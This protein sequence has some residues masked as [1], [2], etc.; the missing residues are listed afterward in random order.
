MRLQRF[1]PLF[2]GFLLIFYLPASG[3][4]QSVGDVESYEVEGDAVL[5]HCAQTKIRLDLLAA[6][7]VRVRLG[8]RGTFERDF[9]WAVIKEEW[10]SIDWHLA[11][12]DSLLMVTTPELSVKIGLHPCRIAFYT[13]AGAF[14][15]G[16]D[17]GKGMGWDGDQVRCWRVLPEDEHYYGFGEKTGPL[18][19]R[20]TCMVMWNS[21]IPG[22]RSYT[23][24]IYASIPFFLAL[25][26]GR[27]YGIYFDNVHRTSF[28]M[29]VESLSYYSFGA[30]G[31]ELD[32]YF[33]YGPHPK[34]VLERYTE[35]V[36]RMP[37]PPRWALGYQQCRWSYFPESRVRE[38][39]DSFRQGRIPCDVIYLDIDYMDGFR[40][41]TWDHS[42]FPDPEKMIDDLRE[43]GF[44]IVVIIDPGIKR[45]PGYWVYDDG[46][47]GDHFCRLPDGEMYVGQVW[48]GQCVF[49]DFTQEATRRWWG[50][51]YKG[52]I[53]VGIKGLWNDMNE[54]A[55]W[56]GPGGTFP[57][58]LLH[59]NEGR[60]VGHPACHNI[61][62]M[63]MARSTYEGVK[64][65]RPGERP[66]V[67]TRA[68]FAGLQRYTAMWTGDNVA[69]WEDLR[70]S[71]PML[72]NIGVSGQPF[73]GAD[74]G[75][76]IGTP[77]GELYA[78][79][80]QTGIFYGLCRTHTVTGSA[81]QEP[82]SFGEEF[83]G[84]NRR[85]IEL[86]YRLLPYLYN[87]FYQ[88]TQLG[89]PVVR[90]TWL[91][92]PM[93]ERTYGQDTEFMFG[94]DLLIG[95][96]LWPG[97]TERR[98]YLPRG[99]W[100]DFRTGQ[101]YTGGTDVSVSVDLST[102]PIFARAGAIIPMQPVVQYSD[103][104]PVD[105]LA[106]SIFPT[107]TSTYTLYEDDG[108]SFDYEDGE[109]ALV[110][111]TCEE[112]NGSVVVHI[113]ERR[114]E[115]T[116]PERWYMLQIH[117]LGDEPR[118]VEESGVKLVRSTTLDG[119]K[120]SESGWFYQKETSTA[121]V[122]IRDTGRAETIELK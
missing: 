83:E 23:D 10:P 60:P 56:D 80:L 70:L 48:P 39:A 91:E 115:Y 79:W 9:S 113:G 122:K 74:I 27:A 112:K 114:G 89:L 99:E 67:L 62:G 71:L 21:D 8:P 76:F 51:L 47:K 28:D 117:N 63:Q 88:S 13:A 33:M 4:W 11:D 12:G 36:G 6:D 85:A 93:D 105:P 120:R 45:E 5:L 119:L 15:S 31:G 42:R 103:Q 73:A 110:T 37:L 102:I 1:F 107:G 46:V 57:P 3:A 59:N 69:T 78:R 17:P 24:P 96:V 22:Y 44:K 87:A 43:E 121:W 52:L 18:D 101:K 68:G 26:R 58:E 86:R 108:L 106:L 64:R 2:V 7:L 19:K 25:R 111:Y 109:R 34:K 40:C 84:I 41:F 82:W 118:A 66:F 95:P 81:D 116:P 94:E 49:P 50:D 98:L 90:P 32:Y 35:L 30:D 54:P 65:L 72:L 53:D 29:G 75:G 16:D 77:S 100:Y 92:F 14:I 97:A 61:Y 104:Q 38:I 20:G 55:S